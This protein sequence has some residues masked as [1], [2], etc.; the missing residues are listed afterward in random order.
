[1]QVLVEEG[2]ADMR[3]LE[4]ETVGAGE[5]IGTLGDYTP[6]RTEKITGIPAGRV[7]KL[8]RAY[9]AAQAPSVLLGSGL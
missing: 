2:L 8:A 9:A 6:E 4:E 7:R 1:M 3:F 5:L